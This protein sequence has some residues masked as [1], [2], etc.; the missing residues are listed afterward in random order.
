M[1]ILEDT[2]EN[3]FVY[4]YTQDHDPPHVHVFKGRK[5]K[6]NRRQAKINLGSE[7]MPPET[8]KVH[9]RM[10]DK[11]ADL[12]WELVA[13]NQEMLLEKWYE[14]HGFPRLDKNSK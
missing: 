11:D 14:I 4:I 1:K 7:T 8:I 2:Q 5:N 9:H 13:A 6:T 3:L 12:A 10:D